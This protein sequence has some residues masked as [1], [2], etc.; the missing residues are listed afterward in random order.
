[1][2]KAGYPVY[3]WT[4]NDRKMIKKLLSKNITAII[5]DR[6]DIALELRKNTKEKLKNEK[7]DSGIS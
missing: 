5:T 3:V 2:K 7:K 6:P 4:V 1:M